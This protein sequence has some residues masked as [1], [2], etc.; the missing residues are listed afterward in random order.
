ML[1]MIT[2]S[3]NILHLKLPNGYTTTFGNNSLFLNIKLIRLDTKNDV[4][5][6]MGGFV[7][8]IQNLN[9]DSTMSVQVF[10]ISFNS[11]IL[12]YL[13][14]ISLFARIIIMICLMALI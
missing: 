13:I 10:I 9:F 3:F 2:L 12:L 14:L 8:Q 6:S 1:L 5:I 4:L 11:F 7:V